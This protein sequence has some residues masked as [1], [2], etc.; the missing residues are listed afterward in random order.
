LIVINEK[1]ILDCYNVRLGLDSLNESLR[2]HPFLVYTIPK[3]KTNLNLNIDLLSN[4]YKK[5]IELSKIVKLNNEFITFDLSKK[6]E[7]DIKMKIN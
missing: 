2:A 1:K 3:D 6:I 5:S 4:I 7:V